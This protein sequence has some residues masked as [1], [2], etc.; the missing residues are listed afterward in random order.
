MGELAG[1]LVWPLQL[2]ASR[3]PAG[4]ALPCPAS[5]PGMASLQ[6]G[7]YVNQGLISPSGICVK[8][9]FFN[10]RPWAGLAAACC[11]AN[12]HKSRGNN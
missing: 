7:L 10:Y 12:Y 9:H 2:C 1:R 4:L 3:R 11:G 8:Y 5:G 6:A